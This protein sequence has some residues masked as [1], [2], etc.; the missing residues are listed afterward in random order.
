MKVVLVGGGTGGHFYP[1]IAIA[2]AV[3][4]SAKAQNIALPELYY[5]GPKAYDQSSLFAYN[6]KFISCPAGKRRRTSSVGDFFRNILDMAK[7]FGGI[8]V[9]VWKLYSIYPDVVMSKGGYTSVPV[10]FAA[11]LLRIPIIIHESDA[12][13]GRANKF[14]KNFARYI[15]ISYENA[16][17]YFP[18]EKTAFTGIPVRT[19]LL[20]PAPE[21]S[22]EKLQ[23]TGEKPLICILGGSQG[24]ERINDL[25][26]SSLD[27]LLPKY[28]ILHQVGERHVKVVTE[29]A[30]ALTQNADLLSDYYIRGFMDVETM[31]QALSAANVVVARAGS[32]TIYEIAIHTKPAILIPIPEEISHDQRANAYAYA[33]SGAASV[34]EEKNLTP[35]LLMSEIE[36]IIGDPVL[37]ESMQESAQ[38]FAKYDAATKIA[39]ILIAVGLEHA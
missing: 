17:L 7:T 1:L 13:P 32:T 28:T 14:A 39:N 19:E 26:A 10:V 3:I 8:F 2:E 18:N 25:I 38:T 11:W 6:I 23:I 9:A 22:R 35:H 36:R 33:R 37:R 5:M 24:A 15:A 16:G 21:K 27:I 29:T 4:M 30:R 31:H 12:V 20:A 34:I